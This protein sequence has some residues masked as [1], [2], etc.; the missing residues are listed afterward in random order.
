MKS[1]LGL[2]NYYRRH[3]QNVAVI[4]RPLT[5]LTRKGKCPNQVDWTEECEKAFNKVKE[6]LTH[7]PMLHPPDLSKPFFLS[8]DASERGFGAVLEQEGEDQKRYPI[9]YAQTLR[10]RSMR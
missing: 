7:P 5:A 3:L 8:T 4:A 1:F 6:L 10:S 2:V 9:A